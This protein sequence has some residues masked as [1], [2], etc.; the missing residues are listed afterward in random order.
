MTDVSLDPSAATFAK[1][2][3][4]QPEIQTRSLGLTPL[5]RRV[6]VLVTDNAAAGSWRHSR[7]ARTFR[8]F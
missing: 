6:L 8:R 2:A 1:T 5:T 7:R 3:I 4:G